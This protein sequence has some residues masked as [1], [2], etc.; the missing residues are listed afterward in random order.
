MLSESTSLSIWD[1]S[2]SERYRPTLQ[3]L[4]SGGGDPPVHGAVLMYDM[5][6]ERSF[7]ELQYWHNE[8]ARYDQRQQNRADR[9]VE[10][11]EC[12]GGRALRRLLFRLFTT[13]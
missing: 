12:R 10:D 11:A 1:C 4:Y 6:N 13:V 3:Q 5:S 8:I 9:S 2:G 7:E